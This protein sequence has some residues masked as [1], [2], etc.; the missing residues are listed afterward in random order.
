MEETPRTVTLPDDYKP[1]LLFVSV[2]L[3]EKRAFFDRTQEG[4]TGKVVT[5]DLDDVQALAFRHAGLDVSSGPVEAAAPA[6]RR[7]AQSQP[8]EQ[9]QSEQPL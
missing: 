8:Q 1:G 9:P 4:G 2:E 7:R 3:G 6:P 5:L